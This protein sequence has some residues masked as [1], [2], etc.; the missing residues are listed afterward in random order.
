MYGGSER[1]VDDARSAALARANAGL[2]YLSV[3]GT[4]DAVISDAF[5]DTL[6]WAVDGEEITMRVTCVMPITMKI[7]VEGTVKDANGN[8][9]PR[10]VPTPVVTDAMRL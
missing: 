3:Q 8:V 1:T 6:V 4:A 9:V 7:S 10:P 2:D 5:G